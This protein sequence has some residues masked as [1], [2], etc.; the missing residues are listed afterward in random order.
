MNKNKN[1][2]QKNDN[3]CV[4]QWK[5]LIIKQDPFSGEIHY[6]QINDERLLYNLLSFIRTSEFSTIAKDRFDELTFRKKM[7]LCEHA[8]SFH[9]TKSSEFLNCHYFYTE[10]IP[11]Y[12]QLGEE[13]EMEQFTDYQKKVSL[14]LYTFY[15]I[16]EI[17][18]SLK[19][20][21]K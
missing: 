14:A 4:K 9:N 15:F 5:G 8:Y 2:S 10:I 17:F 20:E 19:M 3:G 1:K 13:G 18:E 21:N 12:M 6:Y 11:G 7:S 16:K